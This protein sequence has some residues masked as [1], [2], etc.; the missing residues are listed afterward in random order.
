MNDDL[1]RYARSKGVYL[2]QVADVLTVSEATI[3][4]RLRHAMKDDERAA[5][6][7]AVDKITKERAGV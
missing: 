6:V 7:A 3:Y 4:R 5:F 1:K 2:W